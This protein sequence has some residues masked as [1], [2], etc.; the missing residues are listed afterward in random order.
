L[1]P[2]IL[3]SSNVEEM[4]AMTKLLWLS[5]AFAALIAAPAAAADLA[6][7]A[8][9]A[10]K[11]PPVPYVSGWTGCYLGA[12]AGG[13]WGNSTGTRDAINVNNAT[14]TAGIGVPTSMGTSSSG[15]VGGGQ[16]GCNYQT[17]LFVAGLETDLQASGIHG[18]STINS[19]SINGADPT[20]GTGSEQLNWF[21][22][23][24]GRLGVT[25]TN[26]LLLYGTGGLAYGGVNDRATLLFIPSGDGNYGGVTSQTRTGWTA[27]AGAEY[28][29]TRNWSVKAEYLFLDLGSTGVVM[30]DPTRPGQSIDYRFAHHDNIVRLGL[31]YKFDGWF[32][33]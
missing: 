8:P 31:N 16:L 15:A 25:P 3:R 6:T 30:T 17:G 5:A 12:N 20:V 4:S 1:F 18:S 2:W 23:L 21:G 29:F 7:Q 33:R 14:I 22:T 9:P 19:P 13:G 10:Y 28:A 32:G 11:A 27:G 24:R 26:N